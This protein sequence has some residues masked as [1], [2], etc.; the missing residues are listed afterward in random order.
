MNIFIDT[1]I[2]LSFYHFSSDDLEELKK[3]VLLLS[4]GKLTLFLPWQVIQEFQRNR[5]NKIE[6]ALKTF[7]K[8]KLDFQF[9]QFCK[10]YPEYKELRDLQKK[11][12]KM[13]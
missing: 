10:D 9:P 3:L 8:Q 11:I 7:S 6:D 5:E 1:N 2:Y 12:F 13:P 4:Q